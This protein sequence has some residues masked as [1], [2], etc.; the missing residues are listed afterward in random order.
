MTPRELAIEQFSKQYAELVAEKDYELAD[1]LVSQIFELKHM[2]DEEF[3][4]KYERT[5]YPGE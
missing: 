1:Y 5:I 4:T 2:T 3:D